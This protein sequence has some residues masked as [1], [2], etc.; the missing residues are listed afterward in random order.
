MQHIIRRH[1]AQG[2]QILHADFPFSLH[3]D[4][5]QR[6]L[7]IRP[8]P[9]ESQVAQRFL[10]T[11]EFPLPLTQLVTER[12]QQLAEALALV[13]RQ[14]QDARDVVPLRALFLLA[15]ISDQ[16][17][18]VLVSGRHAVEQKGVDVVIQRLVVQEQLAQQA[19]VATPGPLPAAVD[20]EE[21][22]VVVAVD[23]VPRGVAQQAFGAVTL[24]GSL[25]PE[26][27]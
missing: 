25:A 11:A 23:F 3:Q 21:A 6:I 2:A 19:Q 17:A 13:L 8:V 4:L 1:G 20:L 5:N 26:I 16:M 9:E 22:E 15:E 27:R 7:P 18:A 10:R 24:K 14:R 12:D